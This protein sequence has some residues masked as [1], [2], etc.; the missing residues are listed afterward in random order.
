M[1]P[2]LQEQDKEARHHRLD[3][4]MPADQIQ[5][6][7]IQVAAAVALM[8]QEEQE[9]QLMA[10]AVA[11]ASRLVT[12]AHPLHIA[13]AAVVAVKAQRRE[14]VAAAAVDPAVLILAQFCQQLDREIAVAAAV[15]AENA[16]ELAAAQA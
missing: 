12:P 6:P 5:A 8:R 13:V 9:E 15:V 10:A 11:R 4:V 2:H 16:P 7:T 1:R 3:K 14:P